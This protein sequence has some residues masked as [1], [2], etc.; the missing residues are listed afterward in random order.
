MVS[1]PD[2]VPLHL[3]TGVVRVRRWRQ[4]HPAHWQMIE[5]T[6]GTLGDG[7]WF[8]HVV[9]NHPASGDAHICTGEDHAYR[10]AGAVMAGD[11][12]H[13]VPAAFDAHHEPVDRGRWRR[14]GGDWVLVEPEEGC[15]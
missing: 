9:G 1:E 10:L 13:E 11:G 3:Q 14:S 12:W 7:R 4:G 8:C 6:V 15:A 5:V 2:R